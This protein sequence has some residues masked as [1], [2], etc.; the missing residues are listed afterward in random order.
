[1]RRA[2]LLVPG[3]SRGEWPPPTPFLVVRNP[4]EL[5]TGQANHHRPT[6]TAKFQQ[7]VVVGRYAKR[8]AVRGCQLR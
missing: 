1:M 2:E 5:R 3:Q 7:Q 4:V 8:S 6:D